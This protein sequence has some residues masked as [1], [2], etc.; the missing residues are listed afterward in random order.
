MNVEHARFNMVQQQIR[1][2]EIFDQNLLDLY[3]SVK[4]EN[5][6]A[7]QYKNIAFSD[8]EIP[9][10]GGQKMLCPRVE[11]KL[12]QELQLS[13]TDKVLEIGT[14]SGYVTA[15]LAKM[16]D[17]VYSVEINDINKED[18]AKHLMQAGISNVSIISGNGLHGLAAKAPF[19]KIF[20]GGG[21]THIPEELIR[22]LKN[23]GRL[24]AIVGKKPV[25]HAILL[26]RLSETHCR[27]TQLFETDVDYLVHEVDKTFKL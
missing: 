24:V 5:F 17:F 12:I 14:G 6:V 3:T 16:V 21:L 25:M 22:Q 18:A 15:V 26:E 7:P 10:P 9:L 2:C 1:P 4:R 8:L 11:S 13:K 20:I 27:E 19:D 23:G